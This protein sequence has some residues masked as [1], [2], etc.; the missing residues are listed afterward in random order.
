M[1]SSTC[2][3]IV[4]PETI[5][6]GEFAPPVYAGG[7]NASLIAHQGGWDEFLFAAGPIALIAGLLWLANKRAKSLGGP[8]AVEPDSTGDA[9][10][11]SPVTPD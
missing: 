4:T 8:P 3:R 10:L 6:T 5:P 11:N 9:P 7:V 2:A 1:V